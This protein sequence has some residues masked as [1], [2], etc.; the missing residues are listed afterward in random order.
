M[1]RR[2]FVAAALTAALVAGPAVTANAAPPT[3]STTQSTQV[4]VRPNGFPP[5]VMVFFWGWE[6][7]TAGA[8][9][10]AGAAGAAASGCAF[11]KPTSPQAVAAKVLC[12]GVGASTLLLIY[13]EVN[14]IINS[15]P[16][17]NNWCFRVGPISHL[18]AIIRR[19]VASL[20]IVGVEHCR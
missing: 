6:A 17:A 9:L 20:K 4:K 19:T 18:T 2:C 8:L 7:K 5:G 1:F 16:R 13:R 12:S 14:K 11:I 3:P 15:N 10:I